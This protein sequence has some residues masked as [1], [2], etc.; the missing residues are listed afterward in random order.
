MSVELAVSASKHHA[1]CQL[2]APRRRGRGGVWR[3]ES[4]ASAAQ[5][6]LAVVFRIGT[7]IVHVRSG[8]TPTGRARAGRWLPARRMVAGEVGQ[9]L[10]AQQQ[11]DQQA[12]QQQALVEAS[13]LNGRRFVLVGVADLDV[14]RVQVGDKLARR[15]LCQVPFARVDVHGEPVGVD[16]T[17]QRG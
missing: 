2:R 11:Q 15:G 1:R 17:V 5:R 8:G 10:F 16:G 4:V 14:D 6:H 12:H 13:F 3:D 7:Q 9:Q